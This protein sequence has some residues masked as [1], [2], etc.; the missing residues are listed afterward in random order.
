MR[1]SAGNAD[2][3]CLTALVETK[4]PTAVLYTIILFCK[5]G[6]G[7]MC[8]LMTPVGTTLADIP[9]DHASPFVVNL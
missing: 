6:T 1:I 3:H 8:L 4:L 7:N 9:K 2:G 5:I